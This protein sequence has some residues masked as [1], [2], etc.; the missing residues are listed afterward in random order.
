MKMNR[1]G[2]LGFLLVSLI[3]I[4]DK[5]NTAPLYNSSRRIKSSGSDEYQ[6]NRIISMISQLEK[7]TFPLN[8][9]KSDD[10]IDAVLNFLKQ[11]DTAWEEKK[12]LLQWIPDF[13][14]L[15]SPKQQSII[16]EEL[17]N[18]D[19][20][21]YQRQLTETIFSFNSSGII[22]KFPIPFLYGADPLVANIGIHSVV[23]MAILR[24]IDRHPF[25]KYLP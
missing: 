12:T 1:L 19:E 18:L 20:E 22:L 4:P 23:E 2:F 3:I 13:F 5:L 15:L 9:F 7:G 16:R 21:E 24:K 8:S 10:A 6:L 14:I 17:R 25:S 11:P